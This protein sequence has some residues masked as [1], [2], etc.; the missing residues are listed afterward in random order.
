[1]PQDVESEAIERREGHRVLSLQIEEVRSDVASV[2]TD[3]GKLA[4]SFRI[5]RRKAT[6]DIAA[7]TEELA[8]LNRRALA[9]A[10]AAILAAV[11][12]IPEARALAAAIVKGLMH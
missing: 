12:S 8:K 4:K 3:M 11:G 1:V 9:I 6:K 5:L 10:M 2:K 7:L